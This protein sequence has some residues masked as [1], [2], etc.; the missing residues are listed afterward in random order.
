MIVWSMKKKTI[1]ITI[2][3]WIMMTI[4]SWVV[5]LKAIINDHEK[6]IRQLKSYDNGNS[7][8]KK[9]LQI[10]NKMKIIFIRE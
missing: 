1:I 7:N 9:S 3:L 2:I 4:L 6:L 8:F 10:K 5:I